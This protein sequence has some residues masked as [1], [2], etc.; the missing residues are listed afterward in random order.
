MARRQFVSIMLSAVIFL[1]PLSMSQWYV[2]G[3]DGWL[4][5]RAKLSPS[6]W[7]PASSLALCTTRPSLQATKS[8]LTRL[9]LRRKKNTG[10]FWMTRKGNCKW[11]PSK[12]ARRMADNML[13]LEHVIDV[14]LYIPY[15]DL[16]LIHLITRDGVFGRSRPNAARTPI[17]SR[18]ALSP[19]PR[20]GPPKAHKTVVL[21]VVGLTRCVLEARRACRYSH[22]DSGSDAFRGN[23]SFIPRALQLFRLNLHRIV[24]LSIKFTPIAAQGA[25]YAR[26]D[27][28]D[29]RLSR[30]RTEP[31]A[32]HRPRFSGTY[33]HSAGVVSYRSATLATRRCRKRLVRPRIC[34]TPELAPVIPT[35]AGK[36]SVFADQGAGSHRDRLY[37]L[38]VVLHVRHR[39]RFCRHSAAAVLS[40]WGQV[41]RLLHQA[42][43]AQGR[44]AE[45]AWKVSF[46]QVLGT[47][48]QRRKLQ[49]DCRREHHGRRGETR[50]I[51]MP[52]R[53]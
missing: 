16:L 17:M 53:L 22:V 14:K 12:A 35:L 25:H 3:A 18:R 47:Y 5:H 46:A 39:G 43:A 21:D 42:D 48:N 6:G 40:R 27:A 49:M 50:S 4:S 41:A 7:H 31:A 44:A 38:L 11:L 19:A 52:C 26:N 8:L 32:R 24:F 30:K 36:A 37:E 45:Q 20:G 33:L 28:P 15:L 23:A 2:C 10:S 9:R 29:P 51:S 34:R 1:H 13:G